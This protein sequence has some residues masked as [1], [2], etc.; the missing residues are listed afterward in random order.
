MHGLPLCATHQEIVLDYI[1]FSN[2][3]SVIA[4]PRKTI[5][6]DNDN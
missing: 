6:K 4:S 2:M 1:S 3:P 5:Q